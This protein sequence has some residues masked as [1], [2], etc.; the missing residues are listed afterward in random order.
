[1]DVT[2]ENDGDGGVVVDGVD[3]NEEMRRASER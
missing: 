2:D 1:M 3:A